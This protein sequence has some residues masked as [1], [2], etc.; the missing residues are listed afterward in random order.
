MA[1]L[2]DEVTILQPGGKLSLAACSAVISMTR[3][4]GAIIQRRRPAGCPASSRRAAARTKRAAAEAGEVVSLGKLDGIRTGD[5]VS[6]SKTA[7]AA[8]AAS[9]H[10]AGLGDRASA[11]DRKGRR[12]AGQALLRLNEE[13]PRSPSFTTRN[14]DIVC[15]TGRDASAGGAER[16]RDVLGQT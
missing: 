9:F 13:D 14:H 1:G 11:L 5:T 15:G 8:L 12:Q 3:R 2:C 16:L 6:T 4:H 10:S 7:P